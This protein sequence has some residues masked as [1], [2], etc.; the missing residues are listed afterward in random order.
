MAERLELP[1]HEERMSAAR[2]VAQW[3]LGD[4]S[5]AGAIVEAYRDPDAAHEYLDGVGAEES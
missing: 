4:S 5:W 1:D 2:R 3:E